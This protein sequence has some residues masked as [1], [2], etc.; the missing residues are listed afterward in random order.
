M[1]YDTDT[2]LAKKLKAIIGQSPSSGIVL[3]DDGKELAV[4]S[5]PFRKYME[6]CL[7]DSEFG[8]YRTGAARVGKGGDFYTSSAI[9]DIMGRLLAGCAHRYSQLHGQ[10]ISIVEWGAGTGVLSAQIAAFCRELD[11]KPWH[12]QLLIENHS[13][14]AA[15]AKAAMMALELSEPPFVLNTDA[16]SS[17]GIRQWLNERPALL[18]ANELL[19]AFPVSRIQRKDGQLV[20]L[21]VAILPDGS[22]VYSRMPLSDPRLAH[23]LKRDG[24][25]LRE[26]QITEVCPGVNDWLAQLG[27]WCAGSTVRIAILDYGHAAPEYAGEHRMEGTLMTYARHQGG[28]QP[29][30][31]PGQRDITAH[32]AFDFVKACAEEAGFQAIYYDTQKRF[33]MDQGVLEL[34]VEHDGRDPFSVGARRNRAVRQLLLSDGMSESFKVMIL[35]MNKTG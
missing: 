14:H 30:D 24:V 21:G 29:F 13:G 10:S 7:Y 25:E 8:Y 16:L 19:D 1:S 3:D 27:N 12:R 28:D 33:L 35:E 2:P 17:F 4:P 32:V 23:W 18:I 31:R 9:G 20:E 6:A 5:I 26:G 11:A 15:A 34:L 22:F